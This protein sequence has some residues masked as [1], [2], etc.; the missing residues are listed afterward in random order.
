MRKMVTAI[1][2][3]AAA[4]TPAMA[5]SLVVDAR[6]KTV[7]NLVDLNA[8]YWNG[9]YYAAVSRSFNGN[10]VI[11]PMTRD[12]LLIDQAY[13][14]DEVYYSKSNCT[15]TKYLKPIWASDVS[16]AVKVRTNF[17]TGNL[18]FAGNPI[19]ERNLYYFPY[20]G[21][22]CTPITA[23]SGIAIEVNFNALG[24]SAP[25]RIK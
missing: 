4:A 8:G 12:G 10:T 6:G 9:Q 21:A 1:M 17:D 5:D 24:L 25:Y 15:G 2:A 23:L 14:T 16:L 3:F 22:P 20:S 11:L 7:G 19:I 18:M 13:P